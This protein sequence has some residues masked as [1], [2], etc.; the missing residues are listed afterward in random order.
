VLAENSLV[1]FSHGS[2]QGCLVCNC[3]ARLIAQTIWILSLPRTC[4]MFSFDCISKCRLTVILCDNLSGHCLFQAGSHFTPM[5]V[6][7]GPNC[8]DS[9][10]DFPL[11]QSMLPFKHWQHCLQCRVCCSDSSIHIRWGHCDSRAL[12][13]RSGDIPQR[14]QQVICIRLLIVHTD[15]FPRLQQR[16]AICLIACA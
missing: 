11:C 9:M 4:L 12:C 7:A 15:H 6:V 8:C 3:C 5:F 1:C 14:P 2:T 10:S 13:E 16:A